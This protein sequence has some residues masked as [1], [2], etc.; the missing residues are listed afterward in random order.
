MN[1]ELIE[2]LRMA[3]RFGFFGRRQIEDSIEHSMEFARAL[4]EVSDGARIIDLGTGGGLPGLVLAHEF[5]HS[6]VTLIDRRQ[7]RTDFLEQA[8]LRLRWSHVTVRCADVDVVV[9]EV[10][11]KTLT[12]YDVVT[13]RGFGPPEL[14]LRTAVRLAN[15]EGRIVISEPP[16][17]DRWPPELL[18]ELGLQ[19]S[20]V[21]AV[22]LF[23]V[24]HSD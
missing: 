16:S 21:G 4:A 10:S 2:T 15:Q 3:Q 20:R 24:K 19:S 8:V 18:S 17:G 14:T 22:Q 1:P 11:T 13:A 7:K 6:N 9:S 5:P 12:P 23:H